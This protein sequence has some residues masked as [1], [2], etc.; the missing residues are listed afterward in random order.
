MDNSPISRKAYFVEDLQR[1][2]LTQD[3]SP[4]DY[5][6]E[7][8]LAEACDVLAN[9]DGVYDLDQVMARVNHALTRD[10]RDNEFATLWYGTLEPESHRL[11]YCN[12]GHEPGLLLRNN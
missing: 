7:V 12:A 1:R 2:I 4:G 11:T 9:W 6:D 10:T 8:E 3:L 5:L